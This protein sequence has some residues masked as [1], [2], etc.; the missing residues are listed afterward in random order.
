MSD[1]PKEVIEMMSSKHVRL[2][3][4][5]WHQTRNSWKKYPD[6]IKNKLTKLGWCPPRPFRESDDEVIF[7]NN[8]G[9]DF[10]FM[11]RQMI[12]KVNNKIQEVTGDK[13]AKIR[14]W[15]QLPDANSTDYPVPPAY[16][17][18]TL[19]FLNQVVKETKTDEYFESKMKYWE[20]T[21]KD[22][23]FLKDISL[24]DYGALIESTIHDSM[25]MRWSEKQL[26]Y[27]P[28][29]F[30]NPSTDPNDMCKIDEKWNDISY[31]FLA[32]EYGAHVNPVFWKIHGWVDDRISDWLFANK[33]NVG[34]H[35]VMV[36]P[37]W[38]GQWVGPM[39]MAGKMDHNHEM[40]EH[41]MLEAASVIYKSGIIHHC[42]SIKQNR[43]KLV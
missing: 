25:H 34:F 15:I 2:H 16:E 29:D 10:L 20:R 39:N 11:H 32:D 37:N 14:G 19:P 21:L 3:H 22:P 38:V 41:K 17:H 43:T 1:L 36:E 12:K 23:I 26:E 42:Y 31:D 13:Y 24:G 33:I 4:F 6:E 8:A 35:T 30:C 28:D 5:L 40:A 27:R 7:G 18:K 9:E